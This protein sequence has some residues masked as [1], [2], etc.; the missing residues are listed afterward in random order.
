M[1]YPALYP[2]I[3]LYYAGET[4][5][6][7]YT[8]VVAPG[9]DIAQIR[10]AFEGADSLRLDARGDLL[11]QLGEGTLRDTR[12]YAYQE[13][14]GQRVEVAM[15]FALHD[16]HT[17]GFAAPREYDPRYPLVIDPSLE[18]SSFL[19]GS[20][21]EDVQ[22]VAVDGNGYVYVTGVTRSTDFPATPG[23][24]D[25]NPD[26]GMCGDPIAGYYPCKDAF[27]VKLDPAKSGA[28]FLVYATFLGGAGSA[29]WGA[30]I[31]V[32]AAGNVYVKG[33]TSATDFPTQNPYQA[34][35]ASCPDE[36]D[37]FLAKFNPAGNTLLYSTYLGGS[38][39]EVVYAGLAVDG[40]GRATL[41]GYTYSTDFPT[42]PGAFQG[43]FAGGDM[44]VF[45][46]TQSGAARSLAGRRN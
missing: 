40:A 35:C 30:D 39:I 4:D 27:V 26:G 28:A 22:G 2:G 16:A 21:Y 44:D 12:P 36:K 25:P 15:L 3:D 33:A 1:V 18:Y 20:D 32:D 19:G 5:V 24:F 29:D 45:V 41:T 9:A 42:T 7:K 34:A 11:I 14:D 10:L 13:I 43:A 23:A 8:F 37:V 46:T 17:V 31:A 6:L 38:D